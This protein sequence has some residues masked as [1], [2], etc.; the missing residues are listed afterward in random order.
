MT[1]AIVA[2]ND[3]NFSTHIPAIPS[4]CDAEYGVA[5]AFQVNYDNAT[6]ESNQF[7]GGGLVPTPV[8]GKVIIDGVAVPFC[9]GCGAEGSPIGAGTIGGAINW[10]QPRS[11]VFWN[12]D[13]VDD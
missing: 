7:L 4:S 8:A 9:I 11:R 3:A 10:T 6:G 1:G 13:Q 5:T 2:D 12:I